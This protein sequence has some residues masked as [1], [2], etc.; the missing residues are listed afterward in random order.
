[1]DGLTLRCDKRYLCMDDHRLEDTLLNKFPFLR[2]SAR[3]AGD[4]M[5]CALDILDDI[6]AATPCDLLETFTALLTHPT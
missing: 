6:S 3:S 2:A 4:L 5:R 1:M